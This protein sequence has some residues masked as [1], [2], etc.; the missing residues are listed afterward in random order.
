MIGVFIFHRSWWRHGQ[1]KI[2][3]S[4]AIRYLSICFDDNLALAKHV[5]KTKKKA[6]K[7]LVA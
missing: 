6:E 3:L 4:R 7:T 1:T 2:A 5:K